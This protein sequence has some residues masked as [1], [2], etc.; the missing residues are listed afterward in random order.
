MPDLPSIKK[1][2]HWAAGSLIA[3]S[4][5]ILLVLGMASCHQRIYQ[6]GLIRTPKSSL[7]V[8]LDNAVITF[9]YGSVP[10]LGDLVHA[11]DA[12]KID[13]HWGINI[14]GRF[15]L[16]WKEPVTTNVPGPARTVTIKY[17]SGFT[18]G[19]ERAYSQIDVELPGPP[20]RT[21]TTTVTTV[22]F[23]VWGVLLLLWAYPAFMFARG[24]LRR[25]R[26]RRRGLCTQ[27]GYSLTGNISGIC[28][29]CGTPIP[30]EVKEQLITAPPKR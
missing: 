23:P 29:E 3:V 6:E 17:V 7:S 26:R 8:E 15:D 12:L 2:L 13:D 9:Q 20:L 19:G 25:Y 14:F 16:A 10:A 27:C 30:D 1:V 24:P 21:F 5:V 18:Y 4:S 11:R 28:P 22:V